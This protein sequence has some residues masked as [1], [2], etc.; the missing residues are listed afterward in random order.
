[1]N[2]FSICEGNPVQTCPFLMHNG[3]AGFS[4]IPD[5]SIPERYCISLG[6]TESTIT[7]TQSREDCRRIALNS[8]IS[9]PKFN[10]ICSDDHDISCIRRPMI[11]SSL[12]ST[13]LDGFWS[14]TPLCSGH[15]NW[16]NLL[17][18]R[19]HGGIFASWATFPSTQ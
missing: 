18:T 9:N 4:V 2:I 5:L 13:A 17:L 11:R 7:S 16:H 8:Q 10:K 19:M 3:E 6:S 1:M 12:A 14:L 15:P